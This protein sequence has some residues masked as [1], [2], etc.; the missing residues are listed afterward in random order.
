MLKSIAAATSIP[1]QVDIF[2][3]YLDNTTR[4]ALAQVGTVTHTAGTVPSALYRL[5]QTV[6]PYFSTIHTNNYYFIEGTLNLRTASL[7]NGD[8]IFIS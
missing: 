6:A 8:Y 3:K 4:I 2:G 1:I 5:E 7:L